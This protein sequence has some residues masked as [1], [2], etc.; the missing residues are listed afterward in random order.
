M[1]NK[2]QMAALLGRPLTLSEDTNF[3][4]YLASATETLEFVL[5]ASLKAETGERVFGSRQEFSTLFTDYFHDVD[6]V[7]ID[8]KEV[9]CSPR[10]W[11]NRNATWFNSLVFND[12]LKGKEVLV[13][14]SWGFKTLPQ[15]LAT[16]LA[17][18]FALNGESGGTGN[19]QAK[20]IEDFRLTINVDKTEFQGLLDDNATTLNKYAMCKAKAD[21]QNGDI[22]NAWRFWQ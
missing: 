21:V 18:V 22:N 15:D 16:L 19:V 20:E 1:L 11:D 14:A 3:T 9:S 4:E 8:G 13:T 6:S 7:E 12:E 17:R 5:C 2:T 10:Q